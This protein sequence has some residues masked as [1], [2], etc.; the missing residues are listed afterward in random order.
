MIT[1]CGNAAGE[2]CPLFPGKAVRAHWGLADPAGAPGGEAA[3][4]AAFARTW[5]LLR[6]RVEAFLALPFETMPEGELQ[7]ALDTI[8]QMD[9][10][11]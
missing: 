1:V 8:G 9:G 4:D 6:Q 5:A 2:A 11:A 10:A 3:E 7:R